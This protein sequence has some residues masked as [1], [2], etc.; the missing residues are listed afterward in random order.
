MLE[1]AKSQHYSSGLGLFVRRCGAASS[2]NLLAS[3]CG[4]RVW[5]EY[6]TYAWLLESLIL[7]FS[8]KEGGKKGAIIILFYVQIP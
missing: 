2:Q 3:R 8:D 5:Y 4:L 6:A 1:F 7:L